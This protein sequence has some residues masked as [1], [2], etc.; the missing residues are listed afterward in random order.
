MKVAQV[1]S[2]A[3]V[4]VDDILIVARSKA[5]VD[6]V[7]EELTS[8]FEAHDLGEAHNFLGIDII[9]D[10]VARTIK[11]CQRRLTTQLVATYGLGDCKGKS[12][13]LSTS[14]RL[15]KS[16]GE[17]LDKTTFTYTH[18]IG[19]LLYLSV[20]TRPDIAQA[21][22][23]LSKYMAEPTT[24]HWQAA[25][26]LMRYVAS[27]RDHGIVYGT[28]PNLVIGYC[29]ADFA[30]DLDTRR[31]TTG[32]VFILHGGAIT[33]MSKRQSTWR[34]YCGGFND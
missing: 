16:E 11:L 12:M 29:D 5:D 14:E 18:L 17:P 27:T 23:A 7:K 3:D 15:T 20:C 32:Y 28:E 6:W 26:G 25:K 21:V 9:R 1:H 13:P 24:A 30:G 22:G 2:R 10:R 33:W 31:S 4:Y 34:Q 8:K 19:S